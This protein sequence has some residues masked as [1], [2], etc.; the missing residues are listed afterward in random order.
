[1]ARNSPARRVPSHGT[2]I[3]GTAY[4]IDFI[5]LDDEG[6]RAPWGWASTFGTEP[7]EKFPGFGRAE[8]WMPGE[9]ERFF[10]E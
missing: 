7:N 8:P 6:K 1:M 9:N 4:A 5:G 3:A 10:V 2:W